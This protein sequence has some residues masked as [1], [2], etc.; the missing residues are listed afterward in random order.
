MD[1]LRRSVMEG[2]RNLQLPGPDLGGVAKVEVMNHSRQ[3]PYHISP[4]SAAA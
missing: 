1:T 3:Y 4:I 2:F